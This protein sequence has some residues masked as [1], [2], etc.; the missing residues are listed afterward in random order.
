[1]DLPRPFWFLWIGTLVNRFGYFVIPFLTLYLVRHQGF[2]PATAGAVVSAFGAGS[3]VSQP[4]GGWLAD[5]A[6]R[7]PTLVMGML[8]TAAAYLAL[9]AAGLATDL[10]RPAVAA[11]VADLV[12]PDQQ[13]RAFGLLH[14]AINLG[15]GVASVVGGVVAERHFG[16]L[17]VID[18]ATC[19]GFSLTL[20]PIPPLATGQRLLCG[21]WARS[22]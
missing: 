10:Y 18:A 21:R 8:A 13:R 14:W 7:R 12:A 4:L 11:I 22:P 9:G 16:L 17:F 2:D 20:P 3:L 5:R 1:M 19:I 15:V 6:G